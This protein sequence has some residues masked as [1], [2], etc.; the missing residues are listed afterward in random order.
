MDAESAMLI[1]GQCTPHFSFGLAKRETGRARSKEKKRFGATL[2][3][4]AKLLMYGVGVRGCLRVRDGSPTGAAECPADLTVGSRGTVPPQSGCKTA[5]D[6]LLF[7]RVPLRYAL[8][9]SSR[10]VERQRKEKQGQCVNHP[11]TSAPSVT[12][13]QS[14]E[15]QKTQACPKVRRNRSR[16][17]Y[18]DPRRAE[19]NCTGARQS[20]LFFWTGRGPF[21]FPQ[22]GKENGGRIPHGTLPPGGSQP[23]GPTSGGPSPLPQGNSRFTSGNPR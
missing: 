1:A 6:L 12:G 19:G 2:H 23:L 16:H 10:N 21:S 14:Q 11:A 4:R 9:G 7:P 17:R 20:G 8:P 13:R 22:D 3:I 5:F 15:S 18:A